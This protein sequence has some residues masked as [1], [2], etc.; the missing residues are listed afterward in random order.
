MA[1]LLPI[2]AMEAEK[3]KLLAKATLVKAEAEKLRAE[4]P[5]DPQSVSQST[6]KSNP[7]T[8]KIPRPTVDEGVSEGDWGFFVAQWNRYLT[9]TGVTG[10]AATQQLWAACSTSLQKSLHNGGAGTITDSATLL[11]VIKSLAVKRRNNLVNIIELQSMGQ[12]REEKVTPSP[13]ASMAR[14]IC[15]IW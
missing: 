12:E 4:Q 14:L 9:G 7:K 5:P 13:P 2:K 3:E 15:V 6:V 1:H 8:E 10:A 11:N